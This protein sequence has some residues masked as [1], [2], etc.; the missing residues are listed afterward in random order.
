[1]PS[2]HIKILT[3]NEERA[4]KIVQAAIEQASAEMELLAQRY[5]AQAGREGVRR[6]L[7]QMTLAL[8]DLAR[9]YGVRIVQGPW[10]R[11]L[12]NAAAL[13]AESVPGAAFALSK[14]QIDAALYNAGWKIKGVL[15]TGVAAVQDIVAGGMIR[16]DSLREMSKAIEARVQVEGGL[17]DRARADM[18][19]RNETFGVYRQTSFAAAN[20]EEIDLFQMT[21]PMDS[22]T[23][24]ICAAHV[25]Q[26]KTE[27]QWNAIRKDALIWGLHH[28]CRHAF[29][30]VRNADSPATKR[31]EAWGAK[32]RAALKEAA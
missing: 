30:P 10:G 20:A 6:V 22:R 18:I 7:E 19:A 28:Q 24:A 3:A 8:D 26:V 27:K 25:G 11:L 5:L 1:M 32:Q 23:S 31:M 17:I 4:S 16:G 13:G 21:G 9:E 14:P 29:D 15:D 2:N 12:V